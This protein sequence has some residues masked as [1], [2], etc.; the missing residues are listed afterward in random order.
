MSFARSGLSSR[1][2][3]EN[4]CL[5][6]LRSLSPNFNGDIAA[7]W[8]PP[9]NDLPSDK[10]SHF[11]DRI[12][13]S[14]KRLIY[15]GTCSFKVFFSCFPELRITSHTTQQDDRVLCGFMQFHPLRWPMFQRNGVQQNEGRWG[16]ASSN[17]WP[18]CASQREQYPVR[19]IKW[20][21]Y[22]SCHCL[23]MYW[24]SKTRP[25]CPNQNYRCIKQWL[26]ATCTNVGSRFIVLII[27]PVKAR[28][29]PFATN[30]KFLWS[31]LIS[32]HFLT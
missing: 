6:T 19:I 7:Y 18:R 15:L 8:E 29:V 16:W 20:L 1:C 3:H 13:I 14:H 31:Q 26:T 22:F 5:D 28:S 9:K 21:V 32:I 23:W 30:I 27:S 2:V 24:S 4:H 10:L 25:S 17:T 11:G 12:L